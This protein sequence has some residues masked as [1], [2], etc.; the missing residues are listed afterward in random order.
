M[1]GEAFKYVPQPAAT[2]FAFPTV[3]FLF[4]VLHVPEQVEYHFVFIASAPLLYSVQCTYTFQ[5]II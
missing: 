5:V 3:W 1:A 4:Y 2:N